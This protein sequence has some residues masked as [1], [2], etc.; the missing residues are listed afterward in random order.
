MRTKQ[1]P[2]QPKQPYSLHTPLHIQD[3]ESFRYR[4]SIRMMFELIVWGRGFLNRAQNKQISTDI[5][6]DTIIATGKTTMK[7]HF[8]SNAS[9]GIRATTAITVAV[10]RCIV[11]KGEKRKRKNRSHYLLAKRPNV[12]KLIMLTLSNTTQLVSVSFIANVCEKLKVVV[13]QIAKLP[14]YCCHYAHAL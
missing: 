6:I 8:A 13:K 14:L 10:G 5:C 3:N 4:G 2:Y 1:N 12:Q 11:K 9:Y 7:I